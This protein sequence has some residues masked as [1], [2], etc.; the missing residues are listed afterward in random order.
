MAAVPFRDQA[1]A[2]WSDEVER[3]RQEFLTTLA[4]LRHKADSFLTV[5]AL[6]T[7]LFAV[8]GP[9]AGA[10]GNGTGNG[11]GPTGATTNGNGA[12]PDAGTAGRARL[13]LADGD[14]RPPPVAASPP[15]ITSGNGARAVVDVAFSFTVTTTSPHPPVLRCKTG[16]PA[17]LTFR[18]NH[19]G[20]ATI[21]GTPDRPGVYHPVMRAKFGHRDGRY[22]VAQ[23]FTLTVRG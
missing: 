22:V 9:A 19:D 20:T 1:V 5:S 3:T 14:D 7:T 23:A 12:Y 16:L 8:L 11:S 13:H 2:H 6:A 15:G 10:H 4:E 17:A 21:S 18:D